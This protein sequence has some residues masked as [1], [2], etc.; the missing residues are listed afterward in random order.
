MAQIIDHR[1]GAGGHA[2]HLVTSLEGLF[3]DGSGNGRLNGIAVQILRGAPSGE[4]G[5]LQIQPRVF[6]TVPQALRIQRTEGLPLGNGAAG[7][8]SKA[9]DRARAR[10]IHHRGC[11]HGH[12]GVSVAGIAADHRGGCEGVGDDPGVCQLYPH[13]TGLQ[14]VSGDDSGIG[15]RRHRA[16]NGAIK[17]SNEDG[18]R[19]PHVKRAGGREWKQKVDGQIRAGHDLA[20]LS[21]SA[22]AI[23]VLYVYLA[24]GAGEGGGGF[25]SLLG[26]LVLQFRLFHGNLGPADGL[27]GVAAVQGVEQGVLFH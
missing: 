18:G 16:L 27:L 12:V 13:G 22:D 3:D 5:G 7:K 23:T 1:Q 17:V 9:V 6:H 24:D 20:K 25:Q 10:R 26:L 21:P 4:L 2:V 8:F 15:H 14:S 11:R 19:L